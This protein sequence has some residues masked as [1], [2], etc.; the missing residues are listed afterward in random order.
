RDV[1]LALGGTAVLGESGAERELRR[2]L[3]LAALPDVR[4]LAVDVARLVPETSAGAWS[5]DH[6][7]EVGAQLLGELLEAAQQYDTSI[8][9]ESNDYRSALLA[10]QMLAK[11]LAVLGLERVRVGVCLPAELP[12]S[13]QTAEA[14]VG[15]SRARVAAGA[16]PLEIVV[17]VAGFVGRETV[18]SILTGLAIAPLDGRVSQ[19]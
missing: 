10:P 16:E 5:L 7:A 9:V 2:L 3:T 12:E 13:L 15:L 11:A 19:Q 6:D 17:G 1:L 14:L 18:D 8:L 4:A